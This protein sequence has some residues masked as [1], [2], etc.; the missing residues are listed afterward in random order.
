MVPVQFLRAGR[1]LKLAMQD[2]YQR[3]AFL[4]PVI[5]RHAL[6]VSSRHFWCLEDFE[7]IPE[8]FGEEIVNLKSNVH[9]LRFLNLLSGRA[10][11]VMLELGNCYSN[12]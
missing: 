1:C 4:T 12:N 2:N 8:S 10:A 9:S 5:S 6:V 7:R 11:A 3:F